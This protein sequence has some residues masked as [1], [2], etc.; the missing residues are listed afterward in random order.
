[1]AT[2]ELI[3]N[4]VEIIDSA[5][6]YRHQLSGLLDTLTELEQQVCSSGQQAEAT[7]T[8]HFNKV[9]E[10]V[11]KALDARL[12]QLLDELHSTKMTAL[13]PLKECRT[14]IEKSVETASL[15]MAEGAAILSSEPENNVEKILKFKDNPL[16]KCLASFPEL[17]SPSEV[18]Y[19]TVETSP[20]LKEQ[21]ASLLSQEGRVL[22]QAPVQIL[23]TDEKPGGVIVHW[24]EVEDESDFGEFMLQY[25]CGRAA[26]EDTKLLFHKAYEGPLTSCTVKN[27]RTS[28]PYTFRVRGRCD[29]CSPWST[30]SFPYPAATSIPH[31]QWGDNGEAY[32]LSNE[33]R[34]ATR[35]SEGLTCVLYSASSSYT[36]GDPLILR[37]L[38]SADV[39]PGD[40][41]AILCD[42]QEDS[43]NRSGAIFINTYGTVFVDGNEMKTKLPP[44]KKGTTLTFQTEILPNG[45]VRVSVQVDDKE[46][47]LDWRVS[48]PPGG[49]GFGPMQMMQPSSPSFYFALQFAQEHWKVG[50][51]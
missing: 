23:D 33:G 27:L 37:I 49:M 1:M 22:K 39:S 17:P 9:K 32:S 42:K 40:G 16:T 50:V 38:D 4:T 30:W 51:E 41:L 26:N 8:G 12:Q 2:Q 25:A 35:T 47:T 20:D 31:H 44:I 14:L 15:V 46:V 19:F 29:K 18:A 28:T 6:S 34:T 7:L 36:A 10:A 11:N 5:H 3:Q 43:C 48:S 21:L 13:Q 45:K 24:G